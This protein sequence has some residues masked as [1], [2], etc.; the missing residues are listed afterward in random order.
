MDNAKAK[1]DDVLR[2]QSQ[3]YAAADTEYRRRYGVV[4]PPGFEAWYNFAVAHQ[5]PL[6]DD[7]DTIYE[8]VSPFWRLNSTEILNSM[9]NVHA[10]PGG[11]TWRCRYTSRDA[12]TRCS[13]PSRRYDRNIQKL[14]NKLSEIP[15]VA[16][17]DAEFLVNHFDEPRVTFPARSAEH[18]EIELQ[19]MGHQRTWQSLV[20]RCELRRMDAKI[21]QSVE[22]FGLP[23][24][25]NIS[26]SRDLCQHP[27][28]ETMHGMLI[29]PTSLPLIEGFAPVLSTGVLSTM[30]DVLFPSPAY[31]EQEFLYDE[32]RAVT[33]DDMH[34]EV[35][36]AGS[37]TGG[38]SSSTE[39]RH[40]HR[41][42]FVT[43]AK[44]LEPKPHSY[45]I[46]E[47]GVV[48]RRTSKFFNRHLFNVAFTRIDQCAFP[49]CLAQF[50][51]FSPEPRTDPHRVTKSRLVFDTDGNGIS[52]RFYRL[53]ASNSLPLKQTLLRE[54]HDD[55]L[56]PW[57]HY[58][59]VSLGME[60]LPEMVNW[61]MENERGQA[62]AE[63]VAQMGR[64]WFG[65]ALREVDMT[66]YL[67][68]LLLEL[69]RLQDPAR[70]V[71]I[72]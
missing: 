53:L 65:R 58:I 30:G 45:L 32:S 51:Y 39:W 29:S 28:Y 38:F 55:R 31:T 22:T 16:I 56:I 3:D 44:N 34:K 20:K 10:T 41:Q 48:S 35:Y 42:R 40:F 15:G 2:K 9:D 23:L 27:E 37:T 47:D 50:T 60:E 70:E 67:Y 14:F 62:K 72:E 26:S 33:W 5:S 54:W 12:M 24:T 71:M 52:G 63:R 66:I 4:P 13:H 57:V 69:A 19:K 7:F 21:V 25:T 46:E 59:P 49:A 68:R 8:S 64:E 11:E 61:L 18:G 43:L 1:F 17:P 36:W 6:I